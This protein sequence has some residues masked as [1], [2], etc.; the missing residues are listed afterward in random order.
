M[1]IAISGKPLSGKSYF[2]EE[3]LKRFKERGVTCCKFSIAEPIKNAAFMILGF[4]PDK[5][6]D[7]RVYQEL[8]TVFR[9]RYGDDVFARWALLRLANFLVYNPVEVVVIDDLRF[10]KEID[11]LQPDLLVRLEVSRELRERRLRKISPDLALE[12]E[13]SPAETALDSYTD[14]DLEVRIE[15]EEDEKQ[16]SEMVDIIVGEYLGEE[17]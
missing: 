16:I 6:R 4:L 17:Q 9:N 13:D 11:V 1:I 14:W 3:L 15:S 8:G 7:R 10:Q 5:Y 12:G 2:T